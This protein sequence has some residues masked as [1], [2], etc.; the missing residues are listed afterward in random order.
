[1]SVE[2]NFQRI[3]AGLLDTSS[4]GKKRK[5]IV[6]ALATVGK[7][8]SAGC[9]VASA[10]FSL[11][12]AVSMLAHPILGAVGL[13]IGACGMFLSHELFMICKNIENAS[14]DKNIFQNLAYVASHALTPEHLTQTLCK[15]TLCSRLFHVFSD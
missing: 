1:M 3:Q 5:G 6:C 7:I 9:F 15:D 14:K 2:A 8:V 11:I 13:A 12:S 4:E 10:F